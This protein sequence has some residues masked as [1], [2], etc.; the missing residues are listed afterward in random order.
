[1]KHF[2][3]LNTKQTSRIT[4]LCLSFIFIALIGMKGW[5]ATYYSKT[6]GNANAFATWG[7]ATDGTGTAPTSFTTV[8]DI[9]NLRSGS[10]LTT[11]ASWT[12]G[13]SLNGS[14]TWVLNIFGS[15]TITACQENGI[16]ETVF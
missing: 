14:G 10:S 4:A 12:I 7:T 1:M 2:F 8:G 15:L 11:N 3:S 16:S 5:S 13:Q 6:S 9:F